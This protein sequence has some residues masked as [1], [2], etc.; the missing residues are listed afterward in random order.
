LNEG[1]DLPEIFVSVVR[2]FLALKLCRANLLVATCLLSTR[3][4]NVDF[5][6]KEHIERERSCTHI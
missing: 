6:F 3:Q 1:M 2:S 4:S 5:C